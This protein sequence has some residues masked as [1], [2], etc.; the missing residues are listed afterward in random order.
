MITTVVLLM[1]YMWYAQ[2]RRVLAL[3]FGVVFLAIQSLFFISSLSKFFT[4]GWFTTILTIVIFT[5][6][7]TWDTGT[8]IERSQRRHMSPEDFLPALNILHKD[9]SV[10]LYAD[11]L[12][13]LTSDSELRR[14][15]TDIFYSILQIIPRGLTPGGLYRFR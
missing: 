10:P 2:K 8:R 4:G 11:N 9:K 15:D 1:A 5:I 6:M 12:V 7:Y 14:L 13:Y 3:I